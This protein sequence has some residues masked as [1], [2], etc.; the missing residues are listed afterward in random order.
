MQGHHL[1]H[2]WETV[3]RDVMEVV[4]SQVEE[5]SVRR[6]APRNLSVALVFTG[7]VMRHCL[8]TEIKSHYGSIK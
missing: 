3:F 7:R 4:A 8:D 5:A 1:H 2:T 6:E